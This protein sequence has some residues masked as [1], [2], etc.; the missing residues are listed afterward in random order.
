MSLATWSFAHFSFGIYMQE[1][2]ISPLK[3]IGISFQKERDPP[4]SFVR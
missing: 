3:P 2:T 1:V 4:W